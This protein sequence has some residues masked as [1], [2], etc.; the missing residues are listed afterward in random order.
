MRTGRS[1]KMVSSYRIHVSRLAARRSAV[2]ETRVLQRAFPQTDLAFLPSLV[3]ISRSLPFPYLI[4]LPLWTS[5]RTQNR[6]TS[7]IARQG[8]PSSPRRRRSKRLA[9]GEVN[10]ITRHSVHQ[11][12]YIL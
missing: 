7:S 3:P 11:T 6:R 1:G 2:H 12:L 9:E 5:N 10:V 8:T 4:C